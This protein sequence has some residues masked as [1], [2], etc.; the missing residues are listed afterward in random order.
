MKKAYLVVQFRDD[1]PEYQGI[2]SSYEKAVEACRG[3]TDT[4]SEFV[5]DQELPRGRGQYIRM[6]CPLQNMECIDGVWTQRKD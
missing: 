5:V 2:F 1:A 3:E 4:I 6:T